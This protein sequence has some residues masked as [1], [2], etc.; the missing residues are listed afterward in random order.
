MLIDVAVRV[1]R[2]LVEHKRLVSIITWTSF[3]VVCADYAR[4]IDL[5]TLVVLPFW[6]GV[7]L[8]LLRWTVWEGMVKQRVLSR[9]AEL[10]G[11]PHIT[12]EKL[13]S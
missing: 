5:P 2:W 7:V 13:P 3:A 10:D 1:N 4:F 12:G 8:N 9:V 6:A 11:Q